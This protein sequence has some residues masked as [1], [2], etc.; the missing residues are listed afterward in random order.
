MQNK[1]KKNYF[2]MKIVGLEF[3][4][5]L[6]FFLFMFFKIETDGVW[7]T[8]LASAFFFLLLPLVVSKYFF[9]KKFLKSLFYNK[10]NR[11][12]LLF[13]LAKTV[14]FFGVMLC[15]V[16]WVS[17][18]GHVGINYLSRSGYYLEDGFMIYFV[19]LFILPIVLFSQEFFFRGVIMRAAERNWGVM[20]ALFLQAAAFATFE[21]LFLENYQWQFLFLSLLF[22]LFLGVVFVQTRN[23]F[24]PFLVRWLIVL[25]TDAIIL[26]NINQAKNQ[27]SLIS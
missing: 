6:I 12:E 26:Y 20:K 22:S 14:V 19:N 24:Y 4:L 10:I 5:I 7:E 23:V 17:W 16:W 21:V 13:S 18:E 27:L 11:L 9:P 2:L 15:L 8:A 3:V 1:N 25:A